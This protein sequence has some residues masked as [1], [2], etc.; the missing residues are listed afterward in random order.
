MIGK[1]MVTDNAA[2]SRTREQIHRIVRSIRISEDGKSIFR[3]GEDKTAEI[4]REMVKKKYVYDTSDL[5]TVLQ[6]WIYRAY[7]LRPDQPLTVGP[8]DVDAFLY[9]D[10][11]VSLDFW[12]TTGWRYP[13]GASRPG[14]PNNEVVLLKGS[15][16]RWVSG[17]QYIETRIAKDSGWIFLE[18]NDP[19]HEFGAVSRAFN[20]VFG[21][22]VSDGDDRGIVRFYFNLKPTKTAAVC[23]VR[24]IQNGFNL[25]EIPFTLKFIADPEKYNR[26]DSAVLY[27]D[28]RYLTMTAILLQSIYQELCRN[29][30]LR[31]EIPLFTRELAPGLG[32]ADEPDSGTSFGLDRSF[33][34]ADALLTVGQ[35]PDSENRCAA[36]DDFLREKGFDPRHFYRNPFS[37]V[38]YEFLFDH[39]EKLNRVKLQEARPGSDG[40]YRTVRFRLIDEIDWLDQPGFSREPY[41]LAAL[42]I[43]I[44]LC[45][46]AIWYFDGHKWS[47]NWLTYQP[48]PDRKDLTYQLLDNS[49]EAGTEG[50]RFFL[51]TILTNCYQSDL[52]EF[53]V[54]HIQINRSA[55]KSRGMFK[56]RWDL[57]DPELDHAMCSVFG[58]I[59]P[60]EKVADVLIDRYLDQDKPL[61]NA[62]GANDPA[63]SDLFCPNLLFGMAGFGYYFLRV[64]DQHRFK[65]IVFSRS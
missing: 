26:A 65:P 35:N 61:G 53:V 23:L 48:I 39:F 52:L 20:W 44:K 32:V 50:V 56:P 29:Q 15:K 43:A 41:L 46:E 33:Q 63:R 11:G 36:V 18:S 47:C 42:R 21:R 22:H 1:S 16:A 4:C 64:Y 62:Y 31:P 10:T 58:E 12:K 59:E 45:R 38:Q 40:E 37:V 25:H 3:D 49:F 13:N 2:V 30:V 27:T 54:N 6:I 60:D 57:K 19:T 14:R 55:S 34:L 17:G 24:E 5:R 51:N 8:N 28:H 7:Y 9:R